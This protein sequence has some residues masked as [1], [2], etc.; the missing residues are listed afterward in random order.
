MPDTADAPRGSFDPVRIESLRHRI[1]EYIAE[2]G[3]E[4][5]ADSAHSLRHQICDA[6]GERPTRVSQALIGLERS[7]RLQRE[8]DLERHRCQA[9]RLCW[10]RPG[11]PP[12]RTPPPADNPTQEAADRPMVGSSRRQAELQ[13]AERELNDLIHRAADASRRVAE[14]RWA[15]LRASDREEVPSR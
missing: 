11:P 7:G 4:L 9:I 15:V 14:L 10:R 3:G 8:M 13:A 5:R 2:Q 12:I 6:L 1:L